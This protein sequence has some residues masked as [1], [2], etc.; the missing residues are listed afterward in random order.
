MSVHFEYPPFERT[1][2]MPE[3]EKRMKF[4]VAMKK[5][6]VALKGFM[7]KQNMT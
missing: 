5:D 4:R 3:A 2:D 6:C 1:P 7:A